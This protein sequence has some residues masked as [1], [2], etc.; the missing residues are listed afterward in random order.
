MV[1]LLA[2]VLL[3]AV[4]KEHQYLRWYGVEV[5]ED[6]DAGDETKVEDRVVH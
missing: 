2:V 3:V 5:N 6:V 1:V 4:K